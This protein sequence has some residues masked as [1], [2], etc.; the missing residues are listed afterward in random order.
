MARFEEAD[1]RWLVKDLG[2]EGTNVNNCECCRP[3]S[4]IV[5]F[6]SH[7]LRGSFIQTCVIKGTGRS[8]M[9]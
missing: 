1:E 4:A 3:G 2:S 8:L 9:P 6:R 7:G 5:S